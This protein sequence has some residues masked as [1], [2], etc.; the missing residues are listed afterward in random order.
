MRRNSVPLYKDRHAAMVDTLINSDN[1]DR[2]LP[3]H[4][5]LGTG[6]RA[7]S[8]C[9]THK[10][11]FSYDREGNL[12]YQIPGRDKCRKYGT[13]EPCGDCTNNNV[14]YFYPKTSAGGGRKILVS[15]HW[16]NP[17]TG[18]R[19]YF[20]L[21]D[22]VESYFALDGLNAPDG[23][24]HGHEM[25]FVD[26]IAKSTLIKFVREVA[27]KSDIH[28]KFRADRLREAIDL[29]PK[30]DD[31]I[32]EFGTDED[33]NRIPD[34]ITHDLRAS[35]CT[36]LMRNDTPPAKA[37]NKTGHS[38]LKSMDPYI[39]FAKDEIEASEEEHFY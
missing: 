1:L 18:E 28:P 7:D 2:T 21:R 29:D 34:M 22:A 26:G 13:H 27:A 12:Y 8:I 20:G 3:V 5:G 14:E 6:P 24:Q 37:I 17:V 25:L 19:E 39:H 4:L 16:T 31:Q 33:G 30:R 38:S 10:S 9:H 23:L 35:Y 11:W 36:Q 32:K 15:N